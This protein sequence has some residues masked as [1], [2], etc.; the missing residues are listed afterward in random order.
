MYIT[1]LVVSLFVV[2]IYADT[3]ECICEAVATFDGEFGV[4][5][6]VSINQRG[7]V[8]VALNTAGGLYI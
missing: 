5:G 6:S 2:S 1:T 3:D 4:S 7:H 8:S